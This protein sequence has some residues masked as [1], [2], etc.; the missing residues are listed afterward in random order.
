MQVVSLI[1]SNFEEAADN[2]KGLLPQIV[3]EA[4]FD[5]V[6]IAAQYS[7]LFGTLCLYKGCKPL[8][9]EN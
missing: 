2:Y 3:R 6:K 5:Q 1:M 8:R 4:G 7:T 9:K